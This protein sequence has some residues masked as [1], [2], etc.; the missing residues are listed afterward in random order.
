MTRQFADHMARLVHAITGDDCAP[1]PSLEGAGDWR[2]GPWAVANLNA[3]AFDMNA[4]DIH[5]YLCSGD[6]S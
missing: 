6:P 2:N 1:V 3:G 4:H 5:E